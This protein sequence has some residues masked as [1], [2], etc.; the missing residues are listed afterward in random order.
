MENFCYISEKSI[1]S[2]VKQLPPEKQQ[3]VYDF[4]VFLLKKSNIPCQRKLNMN[5]AGKLKEFREQFTSLELQKKGM[6]WWSE[7]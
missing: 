1:F 5:W 2:V 7:K 3:Q 4:A 6:E